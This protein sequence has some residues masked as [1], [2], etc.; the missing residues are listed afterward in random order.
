[1]IIHIVKYLNAIL[2]SNSTSSFQNFSF[3]LFHLN[4]NHSNMCKPNGKY[5][6]CMDTVV[7]ISSTMKDIKKNI[8]MV[9]IPNDFFKKKKKSKKRYHKRFMLFL[10]KNWGELV[11]SISSNKKA[12]NLAHNIRDME[13]QFKARCFVDLLKVLLI[14]KFQNSIVNFKV[15]DQNCQNN[16]NLI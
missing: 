10:K 16:D 5:F 9:R 12:I 2:Y 8:K 1:M 4:Y 13:V 7:V 6:W 3:K 11:Q 14:L 15:R